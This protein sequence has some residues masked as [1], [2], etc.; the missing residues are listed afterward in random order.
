V[1]VAIFGDQENYIVLLAHLKNNHY[2]I[3]CRHFEQILLNTWDLGTIFINFLHWWWYCQNVQDIYSFDKHF[4]AALPTAW[5]LF[6]QVTPSLFYSYC[7]SFIT[8]TLTI[9]V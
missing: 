9:T 6:F 3:N 1:N 8:L 7:P 5:T 2:H 4:K